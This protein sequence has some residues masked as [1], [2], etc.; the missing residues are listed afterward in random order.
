VESC[1]WSILG[2]SMHTGYVRS[3]RVVNSGV[4][5]KARMSRLL[6]SGEPPQAGNG[7][8]KSRRRSQWKVR[9]PEASSSVWDASKPGDLFGRLWCFG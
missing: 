6:K 1:L 5:A 7:A 8:G 4:L 2:V 9:I 3:K